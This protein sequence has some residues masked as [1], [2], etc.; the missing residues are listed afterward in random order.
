[1]DD[2][3]RKENE[4]N[5]AFI[6]RMVRAKIDGVFTGTYAEWIKAVF[7]K[8]HSEDVSRREYYGCKMFVLSISED[9][10]GQLS[11][12]NEW[13]E[14]LRQRELDIDKKRIKLADEMNYVNRMKRDVARSET[15]G[16][17]AAAAA[18]IIKEQTPFFVNNA[19][20]NGQH[21][22]VLC[23]SDWHYGLETINALNVFNTAVAKE[24]L[25]RLLEAVLKDVALFDI[26]EIVVTNLGDLISGI[27]HTA[28]RIENRI[29]VITQTIE[30]SEMLAELMYELSRVVKVRY[31]GVIGN[32]GRVS[33]NKHESLEIEN[34]NRMIDFYL[35][36]RFKDNDNVIINSATVD[37]TIMHFA[38]YNW[39]FVGVHGH[40]D[41]PKTVIDDLSNMLHIDYNVCIMG[42][43]H[44]P[45]L[46]VSYGDTT[47]AN[48]C[49]CGVDVYAK[50]VRKAAKP[51]QN[52]IIVSKDNPCEFLHVINLS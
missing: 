35:A 42:H 33:A 6:R 9:E 2:F 25:Q 46:S 48:G 28:I 44:S 31:Y 18:N 40:D 1:M 41:N 23:L 51:S 52:L 22:A 30:V 16:E 27:I 29:D 38:V 49:L 32:H 50:K 43:R 21:K 47:I 39:A 14:E 17:Y 26:D 34:F 36:E 5:F 19:T 24:R 11:D 13:F 8:D 20:E 12:N 45:A 37:E 7:D 15:I 10:E 3:K 4:T